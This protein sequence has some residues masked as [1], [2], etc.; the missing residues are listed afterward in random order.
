MQSE[1]RTLE[2]LERSEIVRREH[3]S[4]QDREVDLNLI[5]LTCVYRSMDEDQIRPLLS[6]AFT[7]RR[8]TMG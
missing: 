3:F 7:A 2:L 5:Q 4:L 1:D 6:K 8:S